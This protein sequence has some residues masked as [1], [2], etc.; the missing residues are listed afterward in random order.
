[1]TLK[2][3]KATGKLNSKIGV[4]AGQLDVIHAVRTLGEERKLVQYKL[5]EESSTRYFKNFKELRF[6]S[7]QILR[8]K[9]KHVIIVKGQIEVPNDSC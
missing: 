4:S 9:H 6:F 5:V 8:N 7:S 2:V 3:K 1:M